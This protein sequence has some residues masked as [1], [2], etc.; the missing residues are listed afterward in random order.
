[1]REKPT[2][3]SGNKAFGKTSKLIHPIDG[4]LMVPSNYI[5]YSFLGVDGVMSSSTVGAWSWNYIYEVDLGK[6]ESIKKI[7]V[8]FNQDKSKNVGYATEFK[9]NVS[10]NG[11]DWTNIKEVNNPNGERDFIFNL[12]KNIKARFVRV[13]AIK[14]DDA[15]QQG[16]QMNIAELEVY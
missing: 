2:K 7:A 4:S 3:K 8:Y 11:N 12:G 6:I 14:P 10:A 16:G 13:E 9:I 5:S 1:M 15:G